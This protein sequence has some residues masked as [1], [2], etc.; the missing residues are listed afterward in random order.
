MSRFEIIKTIG[1]GGQAQVKEAFD[2]KS[3]ENVALKIFK[4]KHMSLFAL[5]SAMQEYSMMKRCQ[6]ENILQCKGFFED[7]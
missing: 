1:K 2:L 3:G 5:N 4:K 7:M 6:H